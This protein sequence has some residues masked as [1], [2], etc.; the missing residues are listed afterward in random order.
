MKYGFIKVAAAVPNVKVADCSYNIVQM[1]GMMRRASS[2]GVQAMVFPELSITA[3]TC[4]DLFSQQTLLDEAEK[5]LLDLVEAT[6]DLDLLAIVGVPLRTENRLINAAVAFQG[7]RILGVIPKTYLSSY[8][9]FQEERW[10]TSSLE[11]KERTITLG[12]EVYALSPQLL[13][14]SGN[15]CFGVEICEDLW[16][17][18]PSSSLLAMNGANI[19]FNLS[20]SNELIG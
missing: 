3:Y 2:L 1:E 14:R 13:L 18:V 12:R 19:I 4:L 6:E 10:F 9:E 17:P 20:A 8:K 15:V 5:A 16:V 7:G 11:L